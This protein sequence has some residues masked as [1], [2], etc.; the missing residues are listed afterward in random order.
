M[1]GPAFEL[2]R[3][4][5]AVLFFAGLILCSLWILYPFLPALIWAALLVVSTWNLMLTA[6][7]K[8][9][10]R[11]SL[12]VV[13]MTSVVVLVV[14]VP[15]A[16]AILTIA[17]NSDQLARKAQEIQQW[18]VPEPP[19]WVARV[20]VVG[21]KVARKWHEF[22]GLAP[23]DL[24]ARIDPFSDDIKNWILEKAGSLALFFLHL[25][26][27]VVIAA[28]LYLKG[29]VAADGVRAFSRRLAGRRGERMTLLAAQAIRA[30]ALGVIVT[31]VIEAILAGI[32]FAFAGVP[33]APLLTAL[34]FVLAIAQ[35]GPAPVLLLVFGWLYWK[36]E[37]ALV[38]VAF[39]VWSL[40]IVAI[41]HLLRPILIKRG[42]DLPLP[43]IFA[44]VVGG[45]IAFGAIGLFVGPVVLAVAYTLLVGWVSEGYDAKDGV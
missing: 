20:P 14:I 42:A 39:F 24:R 12:A 13:L 10:G 22:A 3:T 30:V 31:A 32:G 17:R 4:M 40:L 9:W 2:V 28:V 27:T 33:A 43:L 1:K 6:Q 18:S 21:D 26:L 34:V 15:L 38:P 44:G 11:R 35:I 25:A 41:D 29:D 23:E 19:D 36:H 8:L 37:S 5:L 7:Q 16:L 45:L